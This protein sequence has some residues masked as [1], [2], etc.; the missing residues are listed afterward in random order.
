[1]I[2]S[3]Y[4]LLVWGTLKDMKT[5][6]FS[7]SFCI[8]CEV[9][10]AQKAYDPN[11]IDLSAKFDTLLKS[12]PFGSTYNTLLPNKN[13]SEKNGDLWEDVSFAFVTWETLKIGSAIRFGGPLLFDS[14]SNPLINRQVILHG[15]YNGDRIDDLITIDDTGKYFQKGIANVPYVDTIGFSK[16]SF[17]G[18][19]VNHIYPFATVD[20]NMDDTVDVMVRVDHGLSQDSISYLAVYYGGESFGKGTKMYSSDSIYGGASHFSNCIFQLTKNAKPLVLFIDEY[21]N[22]KFEK[23]RRIGMIDN[24]MPLYLSTVK[25]LSNSEDSGGLF[26]KKLLIMDITGD[27]KKDLLVT[28]G[29]SCFIYK[30]DELFGTYP[31]TNKN[32]YFIIKSP[33]RIDPDWHYLQDFGYNIYDCGDITG[34]GVPY[35]LFTQLE[36]QFVDAYQVGFFYAGGKALDTYYDAIYRWETNE[37]NPLTADTLHSINSTGRTALVIQHPS[38][39]YSSS[40][41]NLLAFRDCDKIPHRTNPKWSVSASHLE[42]LSMN[43]YPQIADKFVKI[44][45][46]SDEYAD[47]T[48]TVFDILGRSIISKRVF[49]EA[50]E[51]REYFDTSSLSEGSYVIRVQTKSDQQ[52]AKF[53][54]NH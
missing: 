27:G 11:A 54:I 48:I 39:Y 1:M 46:T 3:R 35:V 6:L 15:D 13:L 34:S 24:T 10:V 44:Q 16:L 36:I 4:L 21:T 53:I 51:N 20:F 43:V 33:K 40:D 14:V 49:I 31:L 47:A 19:T 37:T 45:I 41:L 17:K 12:D 50:G 2:R 32:A 30:G 52:Q 23:V 25:W 8:L 28:D 26:A 42:E 7:I 29:D 18:F 5:L 22:D 38:D 9:V